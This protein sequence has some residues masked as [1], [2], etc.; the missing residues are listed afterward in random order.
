MALQSP[1]GANQF[2]TDTGVIAAGYLLFAFE[3]GTTTPKATFQDQGE[4]ASNAHPIVLNSAGKC[5][6]WLGTGEYTFSLR[7]PGGATVW[8]L[9]DIAGHTVAGSGSF[10]PLSGGTLTGAL[11][12]AANATANLHPVTLQQMTASLAGV[13][14]AYVTPLAT[15][16]AT[17]VTNRNTAITN[18]ISAILSNVVMSN[19]GSFTLTIA[20]TAIIVKWGTTGTFGTDSAD[21]DVFFLV[22]FPTNCLVVVACPSTDNGV[23][24]ASAG[25]SSAHSRT[26]TGF[27]INNEG[28]A[29]TFSW[30]A[31]G[32]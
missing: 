9:D 16:I 7:T 21:N 20:G 24:V 17:E 15:A 13:S 30:I 14:S 3:S 12:L 19:P 1:F 8:T 23:G 22:P 28:T 31:I 32:N 18:A 2:L 5:S 26:V 6:L 25:Q 11:T 27:Q 10:L 29:S 4:I